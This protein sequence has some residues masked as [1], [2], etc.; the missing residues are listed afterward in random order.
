[1]DQDV[2]PKA[3]ALSDEADQPAV[4]APEPQHEATDVTEGS[5]AVVD[6]IDHERDERWCCSVASA[7]APRSA[8]PY[9]SSGSRGR[10]RI[11]SAIVLRVIS[12][13]PPAIVIARLPM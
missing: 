11:R 7:V 6:D 3:K 10:P 5:A 9:F 2:Q 12:D 4:E 1:M 8:E 13:V